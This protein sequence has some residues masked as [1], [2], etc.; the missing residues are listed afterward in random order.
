MKQY[1]ASA[2]TA[3]AALASFN[4]ASA[5]DMSVKAPPLPAAAV[6]NWTGFYV[7][8]NLGA[9]FADGSYTLSPDGCFLTG[10]CGGSTAFNPLRTV[11]VNNSATFFTGGLQAGYNWQAGRWVFGVESD[12][13]YNGWNAT[14]NNVLVLPAPL[15]GTLTS[16][17]NTKLNWFGTLRGRIGGTITPNWLLYATGGLA[18]GGVSSSTVAAFSAPPGDT[19][20]GTASDTK[21]GWTIGGGT[22]WYFAP[23]WSAKAEYLY[24]DLGKLNY[25]DGCAAPA[26]FCT[27]IAPGPAYATSVQFREHVAR[28]GINYHF[29]SPVVAKY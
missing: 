13:N 25:L 10:V 24:V 1:F 19:Y 22:E 4:A 6:Y 12:I 11:T 8:G 23:G 2:L 21:V 26:A 7:G 16:S 28:V 3:I 17:V 29:N 9:G 5:A 27:A 14:S 18:Y 20:A 15:V